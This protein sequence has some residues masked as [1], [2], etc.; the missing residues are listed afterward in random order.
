MKI[1]IGTA[2]MVEIHP[3]TAAKGPSDMTYCSMAIARTLTENPI[4]KNQTK[5][6]ILK[7][8]QQDLN[9]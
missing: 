3:V 4:L 7:H 9:H 1:L 8:Q 6:I 5:K 2:I